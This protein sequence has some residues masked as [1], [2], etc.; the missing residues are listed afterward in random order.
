MSTPGAYARALLGTTALSVVLA[1]G[2][3]D[4]ILAQTA[5]TGGRSAATEL[6]QIVITSERGDGEDDP[7]RTPGPVSSTSGTAIEEEYGGNVNEVL[8]STPGTY[9]RNQTDQPGIVVNIRGMQGLGRVNAMID[10]VPQTFRNLSGHAGTFDDLVYIDPNLLAGVDVT[11]GVVAGAAGLG[12]LSG[13]ANFRT[14]GIDDILLPG[15]NVGAMVTG[16]LGTNGYD[17]SG[18]G[19]VGM[20][21]AM[22]QDGQGEISVMGAYSQTKQSN[23]KNGDGVE[24]PFDSAEHPRSGL[25]KVAIAPNDEHSLTLG[26]MW[27]DNSFYVGSAGYDWGINTATYTLDYAYTPGDPLFDAHLAAFHTRADLEFAGDGGLFVGRHGVNKTTGVNA[28]NTSQFDLGNG[29]GLQLFYGAAFVQD[30]YTGNEQRGANPDG[31]MTKAGV[32]TQAQLDWGMV[33]L[34]GGLRYDYWHVKGVTGYTLP[35]AGDCPAGGDL[36]PG[37]SV[38]RDGD[39]INPRITAAVQPLDWLQLYATYAHTFRP[40]TASELFYPGGHNFNGAGN[41]VNNNVDLKPEISKGWDLGL[42]V[43][44]DGLVL[45]G[46]RLRLKVGY[47]N[48]DIEN[49]IVYGQNTDTGY[50]TWINADGTTNM[51]GVEIE[52]T[53]DA[54]VA[55]VTLSYTN[56]DTDLPLSYFAGIGNDVGTLPDDFATVDVGTRWFGESVVLGGR[57]RYTGKSRQVFVDEANSIPIGSYTLFDLYGSWDINRNLHLFFNVENITDKVYTTAVGGYAEAYYSGNGRGRTVIVGATAK[58]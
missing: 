54:G 32:F 6:G 42:N 10:G 19:A 37:D 27:Y 49:Y 17:W 24:N 56:A 58:F 22:F 33:S 28:D 31:T 8:R 18:M 16:K 15:R 36:C 43:A 21:S 52:G 23:Y 13:A 29:L 50:I 41:P 11:R 47:F 55:Y 9:T 3:P 2:G 40:P 12:T 57:M 4:P 53:Y 14:I 5:G 51:S 48:N 35:G 45:D 25:F 7:Y 20:R 46:D 34:L 30:D 26:G 38:S 1:A 39:R 44:Y